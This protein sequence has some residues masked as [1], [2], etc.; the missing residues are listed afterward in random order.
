MGT[1]EEEKKGAGSIFKAEI[2][3]KLPELGQEQMGNIFKI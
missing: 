2:V 1:K 3:E